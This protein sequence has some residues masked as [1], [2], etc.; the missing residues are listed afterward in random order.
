MSFNRFTAF[1]YADP[2][3]PLAEPDPDHIINQQNQQIS[4][5]Q[6]QLQQ[7]QNAYQAISEKVNHLQ[8]DKSLHEKKITIISRQRH[9]VAHHIIGQRYPKNRTPCFSKI[10]ISHTSQTHII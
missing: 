7:S 9:K 2:D 6:Q 5:L 10:I 1:K 4:F 3:E 8:I